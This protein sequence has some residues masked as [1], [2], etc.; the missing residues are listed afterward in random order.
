MVPAPPTGLPVARSE[1]RSVRGP[2]LGDHAP[3]DPGFARGSRVPVVPATVPI[4]R[5]AGVGGDVGGP[6]GLGRARLQPS[7]SRPLRGGPGDRPRARLPGP[8]R[9]TRIG[10]T[11]GGRPLHCGGGGIHGVRG[12]VAAVDTNVRR[13]VARVAFGT[14]SDGVPVTALREMAE[15]WLD[16][17]APGYWNQALMDLGREVCRPRPR[18]AVCPLAPGCAF[19]RNGAVPRSSAR[20]QPPFEGSFRQLRGRVMRVLR[21]RPGASLRLLASESGE[22]LE[23]VAAAVVALAREDLVRAG[24]AALA[25]RP[26]G[27][28]RLA[29]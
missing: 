26:Q 25:G 7:R 19:L 13:I 29:G 2:G 20:R 28:A 21:E 17:D 18:C 11:A 23:R 24:P 10:P 6:A 9:P 14:E 15:R 1:A 8:L 4:R 12:P 5:G 16:P 3:A 22:P 27:R